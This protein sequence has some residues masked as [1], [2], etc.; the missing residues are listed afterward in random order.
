[1]LRRDYVLHR[2]GRTQEDDQLLREGRG[3]LCAPGRQDW[4]EPTRARCVAQNASSTSDDGDGSDD[5]HDSSRQSPVTPARPK[6]IIAS[7]GPDLIGREDQ[8]IVLPVIFCEVEL[9]SSVI[10][11]L[12]HLA[13][14]NLRHDAM[15][16]AIAISVNNA[17]LCSRP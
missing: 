11:S 6:Q 1:M 10:A 17:D 7:R 8:E 13:L 2:T 4:L 5:L 3:W 16:S 14:H 9:A 12:G 15:V